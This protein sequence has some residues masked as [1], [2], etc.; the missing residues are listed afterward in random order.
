MLLLLF[1]ALLF[2]SLSIKTVYEIT[3]AVIYTGI[4]VYGDRTPAWQ[5]N[6]VQSNVNAND[7]RWKKHFALTDQAFSSAYKFTSTINSNVGKCINTVFT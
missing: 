1:I 2:I 4:S 7:T 6:C 5:E 3:Y